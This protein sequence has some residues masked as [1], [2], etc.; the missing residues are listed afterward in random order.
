MNRDFTKIVRETTERVNADWVL[1]LAT[2]LA[3]FWSELPRWPSAVERILSTLSTSE[4]VVTVVVNGFFIFVALYVSIGIVLPKWMRRPFERSVPLRLIVALTLLPYSISLYSIQLSRTYFEFLHSELYILSLIC[5]LILGFKFVQDKP[6]VHPKSEVLEPVSRL[7][8]A[9]EKSSDSN[10]T[11]SEELFEQM[12]GKGRLFRAGLQSFVVLSIGGLYAIPLVLLA[13]LLA[14]FL[15]FY[16]LLEILAVIKIFS[17]RLSRVAKSVSGTNTESLG[18]EKVSTI[19]DIETA[20]YRMLR[21]AR[22]NSGKGGIMAAILGLI[23]AG[24]YISLFSPSVNTAQWLILYDALTQTA[25]SP[26]LDSLGYATE[27]AVEATEYL[28][29]GITPF[30]LG[31]YTI[32]FWFRTL[33]RVPLLPKRA[34]P[35]Y[36]LTLEEWT[37]PARPVGFMIPPTLMVLIWFSHAST[38]LNW[39]WGISII[40]F[41][42]EFAV[43]W[44]VTLALLFASVLLTYRRE[45]EKDYNIYFEFVVPLF[46]Q[47]IA[48]VHIIEGAEVIAV[49]GMT[50]LLSMQSQYVYRYYANRSIRRQ[51]GFAVVAGVLTAG[52]A[53]FARDWIVA[54]CIGIAIF[55]VFALGTTMN[56]RLD[57]ETEG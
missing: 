44:L 19:P 23:P 54:I 2:V 13:T 29:V 57:T 52:V 18:L 11:S 17:S 33:R 4:L 20:S 55:G 43:L 47:Y 25:I 1:L 5:I 14:L 53:S 48:F 50:I 3:V 45:P 9:A 24:M 56:N 34:L 21:T 22:T 37:P 16:P 12:Q 51:Y 32:W 27:K 10:D 7:E 39:P 31:L 30:V 40:L 28:A 26:S 15:W 42:L 41:K 36:E 35:S 6:L 38:A 49:I 8:A 46:I